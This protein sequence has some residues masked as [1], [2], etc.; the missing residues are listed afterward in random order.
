M[1]PRLK[2]QDFEKLSSVE[3][4]S[5]DKLKH[6]KGGGPGN[7][8]PGLQNLPAHAKGCPPPIENFS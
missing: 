5:L 7:N 2:I 1:K 6:I 4:V 8:P 3:N